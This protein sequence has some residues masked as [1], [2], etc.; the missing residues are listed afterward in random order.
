MTTR[1]GNSN[2]P[3]KARRAPKTLKVTKALKVPILDEA[4]FE[5]LAGVS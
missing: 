1:A 4:E 3:P 2:A 5:K